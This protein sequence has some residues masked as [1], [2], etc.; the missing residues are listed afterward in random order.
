MRRPLVTSGEQM[1]QW[2]A[3][4]FDQGVRRPG[5]PADAW[6]ERWLVDRFVELGLS[7][8]RLEPVPVPTWF[9]SRATVEVGGEVLSGFALPHTVAS[10]RITADLVRLGDEPNPAVQSHIAVSELAFLQV[11]QS[12]MRDAAT[13]CYDPDGDFDDLVQTLPFG[14]RLVQVLEPALEQQAAAFVG[15]L[16]G[17]PWE[18]CSYYVPYDAKERDILALWL[19]PSDG[20]RLLALMDAGART[21]TV[22]VD[23]TSGTAVS[24]NVVAT[25]PGRSTECV[26]IGSHHDG[27]WSS[28]VEDASGVALVLAQAAQWAQVPVEERPHT[29]VF[30]VMAGHMVHGAGTSRFLEMH[31]DLVD[32]IV[33]EIHLEHVARRC[34]AVGGAL[35]P[36]DEPEP[37]WWFTSRNP[38]LESVVAEVIA[39]HDLRRSLVVPPDLFDVKPTTDGADFHPAGVPL[40]QLLAAPMYLFDP[41]DTL[42]KVHEPSFA[43]IT[44]AVR[45]LIASTE[46]VSAAAMRAGI[47]PADP[48]T[49]TLRAGG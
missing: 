42:D 14:E 45:D 5:Y 37:R 38:A 28:A 12:L 1:M 6:V 29:L 40:V 8:V 20:R 25:L 31:A 36:L 39:E 17:V 16:T 27:P 48:S 3:E 26:V 47:R 22:D 11:P 4:I 7:E 34:I 18:T 30:A 32:R 15:C 35:V 21:A 46:G 44:L 24:H 43:P 23:G 33:L 49:A 2:T 13:S 41:A 9:P 19:S 10:G